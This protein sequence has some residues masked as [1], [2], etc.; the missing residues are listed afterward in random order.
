[1]V[2][3][4]ALIGAALS[5]LG[6]VASTAIAGNKSKQAN[7]AAA[8][9]IQ[10]QKDKNAAWYNTKMNEDYT[11]RADAQA[12][13]QKQRELLNEQYKNARAT[14]IV[15]GGSDAQLAA[16]KQLANDAVADTMSNIAANAASAK[17]QAEQEYLRRDAELTQQQA[18][19][20][21]GQANASA[22]AG[23]QAA[24]AGVNL[25]GALLDYDKTN[26]DENGNPL[27]GGLIRTGNDRLNKASN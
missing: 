20:K 7:E 26:R 22:Q 16:Q 11:K 8:R 4:G 23:A 9:L 2:I 12:V 13:I 24:G 14:N 27:A 5:A 21:T 19:V 25:A 6:S 3:T 18:G 17:D 1:M 15:A 10:Q